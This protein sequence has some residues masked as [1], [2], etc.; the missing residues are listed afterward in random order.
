MLKLFDSLISPILLYG[1][2][3]WESYLNQDD[4][5][6]NKNSSENVHLMFTKRLLGLYRSTSNT[7]VRGELGRYSLRSKIISIN[8]KY[9]TQIKQKSDNTLV[10][11]AYLYEINHSQNMISIENTAKNI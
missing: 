7:M 11:Q 8:T 1:S 5:K 3:L 10:K 6:W 9:L 4:E 2:E